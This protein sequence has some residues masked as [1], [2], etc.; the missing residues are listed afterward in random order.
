MSGVFGRIPTSTP[1]TLAVPAGVV[2]NIP[3]TNLTPLQTKALAVA[4]G[5]MP[6]TDEDIEGLGADL[7]RKVQETSNK[8]ISQVSVGQFGELGDILAQVENQVQTLDPNSLMG[9]G[10]AGWFRRTFTDLKLAY[11]KRFET[12]EESFKGLE[13]Q[14]AGH[15]TLHEG[16]I[17]DLDVLYNENYAR[18][19]ELTAI[20]EKGKGLVTYVEGLLKSHP[21]IAP[22]DPDAMMKAQL[23]RDDEA[24][25]NRLRK[26]VDDFIRQRVWVE[27]LAPRIRQQQE[28]SRA[29][30]NS[31][32][33]V[34]QT[35]IP[36]L[37]MEFA[38]FRQSLES[39]T[40]VEFVNTLKGMAD[41]AMI[42]SAD[43]AKDAAV[44]SAQALNAPTTST[45]TLDHIRNRAL[46]TITEVRR[47]ET[48]AQTARTTEAAHLE[49][50][51][52]QYLATLTKLGA[53]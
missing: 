46:E 31:L 14:I 41:A 40:S 5:R 28:T 11:T 53:I 48:E 52:Q 36:Q 3:L 4:Q 19:Q 34:V 12:A 23:L 49:S 38:L 17:K 2:P 35:T 21:T 43:A 7:P 45:S 10:V 27:T 42:K 22:N 6:I 25:L 37:R 20:I 30:K 51:Q 16:R 9:S 29:V 18:Y 13:A 8:V 32:K 24:K 1:T 44:S 39:K 15:M 26:R 47:I 33:D 50:S